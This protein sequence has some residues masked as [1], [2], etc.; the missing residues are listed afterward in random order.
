MKLGLAEHFNKNKLHHAYL[1]E[2]N[3]K[4]I[5]PEVLEFLSLLGLDI[6]NNPDIY[7]ISFDVLKIDDAKEI[8]TLT[9]EKSF[10]NKKKIFLIVVNDILLQA[11][12]TLLKT[13]EEPIE[14]TIFF[15]I[16][17]NSSFLLDTLVSRFYL[18]KTNNEEKKDELKEA[19]NFILMTVNQRIDFIKNFLKEEDE[20][21][22]ES[23]KTKALRL[24]NELELLLHNK[25]T[26]EQKDF[27]YL[28]HLLK[29]REYLNQPGSSV[30][31]LLESLALV[32]PKF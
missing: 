14:N 8:K 28:E 7:H 18:I 12:N 16:T 20:E 5:I 11:Q 21:A 24:V 26:S 32:I 29:V 4:E 1:I 23:K 31:T 10:G 27:K 17:P 3:E 2:G 13:F 6:H 15:L 22:E 30:K 19:E 25:F 9:T